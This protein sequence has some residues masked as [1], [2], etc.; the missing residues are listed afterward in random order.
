LTSTAEKTPVNRPL[1]AFGALMTLLAV[2]MFAVSSTT[3]STTVQPPLP[4]N[5]R[6]KLPGARGRIDLVVLMPASQTDYANRSDEGLTDD[7]DLCSPDSIG[8]RRDA[9]A[10][11]DA[12]K[13]LSAMRGIDRRP[14]NSTRIEIADNGMMVEQ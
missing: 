11:G 14:L 13:P 3:R 9:T 12:L 2:A 1:S 4:A 10:G 5:R 8:I 6:V 7:G